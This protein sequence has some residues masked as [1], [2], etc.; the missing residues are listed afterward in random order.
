VVK[1]PNAPRFTKVGYKR[2]SSTS[3][4]PVST[5][6]TGISLP[7]CTREFTLHWTHGS[8]YPSVSHT[9]RYE[10]KESAGGSSAQKLGNSQ[11]TAWTRTTPIEGGDHNYLL[12]AYYS[13]NSKNSN[14]R[15]RSLNIHTPD[16]EPDPPATPTVTQDNPGSTDVTVNWSAPSLPSG[17]SVQS[18]EVKRATGPGGWSEVCSPGGTTCSDTDDEKTLGTTY[19]YRVQAYRRGE[20]IKSGWSDQGTIRL[21][22]AEPNAPTLNPVE[23]SAVPDRYTLSWNDVSSNTTGSVTYFIRE[24]TGTGEAPEGGWTRHGAGTDKTFSGKSGATRYNYQIRACNNDPERACSDPSNT[25]TIHIPGEPGAPSVAVTPQTQGLDYTVSW[26]EAADPVTSYELD[27]SVDGGAF[28][29]VY[30]DAGTGHTPDTARTPG[31]VYHYRVR[32]LIGSVRGAYSPESP[33]YW[34]PQKPADVTVNEASPFTVSWPDLSHADHYKVQQSLNGGGAWSS[35]VTVFEGS[36]YQPDKPV[37]GTDYQYQV[38][39]CN[40][41]GACSAYRQSPP[42]RIAYSQPAVPGPLTVTLF[43]APSGPPRLHWN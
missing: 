32:A 29:P 30:S 1:T 15:S 37:A 28:E 31:S 23:Q 25:A 10:L 21:D 34:V 38:A 8:G 24:W 19:R 17:F 27:E 9:K 42:G 11:S 26:T 41:R 20:A 7:G 35:A 16:C 13:W 36:E 39:A 3:A 6:T 4:V 33:G 22:H 14:K 2:G 40:G 12:Y 43:D 18:Y 5:G